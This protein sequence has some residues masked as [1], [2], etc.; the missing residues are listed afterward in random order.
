MG[1]DARVQVQAEATV[2]V[3][4]GS[5][6]LPPA[7]VSPRPA[8]EGR[9]KFMWL[10][11]GSLSLHLPSSLPKVDFPFR[12]HTNKAV[13]A[14]TSPTTFTVEAVVDTGQAP[15]HSAKARGGN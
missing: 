6:H 1:V 14:K 5:W 8:G 2:G 7:G 11:A 15:S 4:C 10:T 13:S 3:A 9:E 12:L